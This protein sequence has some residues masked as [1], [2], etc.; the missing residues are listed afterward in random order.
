MGKKNWNDFLWT[1]GLVVEFA[2][3]SVG[4]QYGIY[5]GA[6]TIKDKLRIFKMEKSRLLSKKASVT[7]SDIKKS[8]GILS[9][10]L[11]INSLKGKKPYVMDLGR[12]VEA[13]PS[14]VKKAEYFTDVQVT[15]I[16]NLLVA[17]RKIGE[18]IDKIKNSDVYELDE[19]ISESKLSERAKNVCFKMSGKTREMDET[20]LS[21]IAIIP[22]DKWHKYNGM[23]TG[24]KNEIREYLEGNGFTLLKNDKE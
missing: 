18:E 5:D 21:D 20:M 19:K 8:G 9:A 10:E 11:H 17:Q 24:T 12:Y 15:H 2:N 6:K 3:A 13:K 14:Q 4:G 7:L 23:G 22:L 1:D 16:N